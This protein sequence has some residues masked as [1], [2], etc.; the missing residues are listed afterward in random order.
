MVNLKWWVFKGKITRRL[1]KIIAKRD[2]ET[3]L[4]YH[5]LDGIKIYFVDTWDEVEKLPIDIARKFEELD[6]E[7]MWLIKEK[8]KKNEANKQ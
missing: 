7:G 3:G 6:G 8:S 4:K 5:M 1:H 2:E